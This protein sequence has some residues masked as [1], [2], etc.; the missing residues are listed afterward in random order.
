MEVAGLSTS[1]NERVA[2]AS[3]KCAELLYRE[4]FT[5]AQ[6]RDSVSELN[7][8][9][10]VQ[11]GLIKVITTSSISLHVLGIHACYGT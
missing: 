7:N 2:E 9:L 6:K 8:V 5:W 3:L 11:L 1:T 10:L 4:L